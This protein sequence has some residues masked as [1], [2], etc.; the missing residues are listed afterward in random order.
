MNIESLNDSKEER[1]E[2]CTVGAAEHEGDINGIEF[3]CE[4]T[5][6]WMLLQKKIRQWFR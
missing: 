3:G 1:V 2:R 4:I 6:C 5:D